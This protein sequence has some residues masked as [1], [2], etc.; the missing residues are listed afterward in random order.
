MQKKQTLESSATGQQVDCDEVIAD[1][2]DGATVRAV[3]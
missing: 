1:S 3:S 2:H